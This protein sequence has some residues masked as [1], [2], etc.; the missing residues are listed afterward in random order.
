MK[1]LKIIALLTLVALAV[2][3]LIASAYA[4]TGGR[5]GASTTPASATSGTAY[6]EHFRR[7][8]EQR[9][10][11]GGIRIS[12]C[13][14][15]TPSAIGHA[16]TNWQQRFHVNVPF[17]DWLLQKHDEPNSLG[18]MTKNVWMWMRL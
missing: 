13:S 1:T 4:Y 11:D 8:D 2:S 5:I 15:N 9:R 6:G 10:D 17:Y 18:E 7:N 16:I 12:F 14:G 3:L